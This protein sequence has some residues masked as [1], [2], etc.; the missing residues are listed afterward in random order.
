MTK[1]Y[2][3]RIID[4]W[5]GYHAERLHGANGLRFKPP[6]EHARRLLNETYEWDDSPFRCLHVCFLRRSSGKGARPRAARHNSPGDL[7]SQP[8]RRPVRL[9]RRL[10]VAAGFPPRSHEHKYYRLGPLVTVPATP[11][12]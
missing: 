3:F 4:S 7:Y 5:D 11:F 1:L 9:V 12:L 10:R 6:S 2:N 8:R